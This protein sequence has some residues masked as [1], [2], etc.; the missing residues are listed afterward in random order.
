MGEARERL[1][2]SLIADVELCAQL[3]TSKRRRGESGEHGA[4]E[5]AIRGR[6]VTL[7]WWCGGGIDELEMHVLVGAQGEPERVWCGCAAMLD[8]E[9]E[10]AL[11]AAHVEQR[12]GP[13]EEVPRAA[14]AVAGL[15]A[16]AVFAGVVHDEDGQIVGP[17]ELAQIA[18]Q[19]RDLSSVVL[20]DA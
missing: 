19:R 10:L 13:G 14:Q 5:S 7:R 1:A 9:Q 8:G 18:E 11:V 20:V 3:G 16:R 2:E 17:R 12:V 15:S 4:I 6:V